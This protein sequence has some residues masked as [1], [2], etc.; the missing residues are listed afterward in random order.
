[1]SYCCVPVCKENGNGGWRW[2]SCWG[3]IIMALRNTWR[4][5]W[6]RDITAV[7]IQ[8]NKNHS[9]KKLSI[10]GKQWN[11]FAEESIITGPGAG[12]KCSQL[13][14]SPSVK[15]PLCVLQRQDITNH[16]VTIHDFTLSKLTRITLKL[17]QN[18]HLYIDFLFLLWNS[19]FNTYNANHNG[20]IL[21]RISK[22]FWFPFSLLFPVLSAVLSTLNKITTAQNNIPSMLLFV[23]SKVTEGLSAQL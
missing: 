22:Y 11:Y 21:S 15:H 23:F 2:R 10:R 12:D 17:V 16:S 14:Q 5:F 6:N 20:W 8:F 13:T 7:I 19:S 1:M 9:K 4:P 3:P 18:L